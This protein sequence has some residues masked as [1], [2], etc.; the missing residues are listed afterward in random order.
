[1]CAT[2]APRSIPAAPVSAPSCPLCSP[3]VG[4]GAAGRWDPG[5]LL[6]LH[7]RQ[8][9]P[10]L[11]PQA[12]RRDWQPPPQPSMGLRAAWGLPSP[13]H[14]CP[15]PGGGGAFGPFLSFVNLLSQPK[16]KWEICHSVCWGG[17]TSDPLR[18]GVTRQ[19]QFVSEA[20]RALSHGP[21]FMLRVNQEGKA[22][23]RQATSLGPGLSG[24]ADLGQ[25]TL[26][27]L[28]T[29]GTYGS[30]SPGKESAS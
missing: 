13:A 5:E 4:D 2:A 26:A 30:S 18:T 19:K 24:A 29:S 25:N 20:S 21:W 1:M 16:S 8:R 28:S 17:T 11:K 10:T 6:K 22:G 12:R 9:C 27:S 23:Q 15:R 14:I 7:C 3:Q